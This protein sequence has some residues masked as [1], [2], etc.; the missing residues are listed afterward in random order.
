M[1][2]VDDQGRH[3]V[4]AMVV[5]GFSHP[6]ISL[7]Y[8]LGVVSL[9]FHLKHG[10]Q[11]M[12]HTLGFNGTKLSQTTNKISNLLSIVITLLLAFIP[13]SILLGLVK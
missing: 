7:F 6:L 9:G 1:N 8:V 2:M 5:E 10:I 12:V 3:D 4:Y 11:S 13:I